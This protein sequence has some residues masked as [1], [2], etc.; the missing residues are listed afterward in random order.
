MNQS[1]IKEEFENAFELTLTGPCEFIPN[2]GDPKQIW[3]FKI[4]DEI[5]VAFAKNY[6]LWA[7]KW[8]G[9]RCAKHCESPVGVVRSQ[10][11]ADEIRQLIKELQ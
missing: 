3:T 11:M 4:D 7:A 5:Q 2:N 9:E 10:K 1:K 6:A 8:M